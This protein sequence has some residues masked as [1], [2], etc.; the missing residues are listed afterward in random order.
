[1]GTAAGGKPGKGLARVRIANLPGGR[2]RRERRRE[3]ESQQGGGFAGL[4]GRVKPA[5]KKGRALAEVPLPPNGMLERRP[6]YEEPMPSQAALKRTCLRLRQ[7]A[8]IV[9]AS[10][11]D[12]RDLEVRRSIIEDLDD[13]GRLYLAQT[14][15]PLLASQA[16]RKLQ[17]SFLA[18]YH[19]VPGGRWLRVGYLTPLKQVIAD[20]HLGDR[21]TEPVLVVEGPKRLEPLSVRAAYRLV[22]PDD[23]ELE[24]ALWPEGQPLGLMD[25]S[26]S[27]AQFY[28]DPAWSFPKGRQ[29][30]LA[31]I[32][33]EVRLVMAAEVV[34]T[35]RVRDVLGWERKV[36]AVRFQEMGPNTR[37]KLMELLT[38]TYR[39]LLARRSGLASPEE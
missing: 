2:S 21:F 19:D 18:R 5:R 24:L 15:P 7:H 8:D 12:R 27:G 17:I 14:N 26:V 31:L 25:I 35:S 29:L 16:G 36:A 23:L 13:R 6:G 38:E 9:P 3:K 39:H 1:M 28:Y 10:E 30:N 20:Y 4:W 32:S 22:P 33:G 11:L 34:R 37:R